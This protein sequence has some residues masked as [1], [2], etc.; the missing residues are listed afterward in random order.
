MWFNIAATSGDANAVKNRD[1]TTRKMTAA[2]IAK[3]QDL[4]RACVN[5][6]YKDCWSLLIDDPVH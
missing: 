2:D 4:A 6:N 1:I 5:K 3:A